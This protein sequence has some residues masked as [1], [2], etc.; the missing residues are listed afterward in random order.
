MSEV[1]IKDVTDAKLL[2]ED[3][4]ANTA[5]RLVYLPKSV[6]KFYLDKSEQTGKKINV[7]FKEALVA[8]AVRDH[9]GVNDDT[10][11]SVDEINAMI[12]RNVRRYINSN[13]E[14]LAKL[15]KD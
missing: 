4:D 15:I 13:K 9:L 7:I 1:E 8:W 5:R 14:E 3:L 10:Q 11:M 6:E 12:Y 2:F